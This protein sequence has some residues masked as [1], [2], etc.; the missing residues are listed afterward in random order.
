MTFDWS[1][2]FQLLVLLG[3]SSVLGV[4]VKGLLDRRKLHV[5]TDSVQVNI[6]LAQMTQATRDVG[7]MKEEIRKVRATIRAHE[8]WDR[9]VIRELERANITIE[10][11]P[12]LFWL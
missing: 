7:D 3:G 4:L 6:A 10:A 11:P 9:Q 5:D 1:L 8:I 12:E 2:V